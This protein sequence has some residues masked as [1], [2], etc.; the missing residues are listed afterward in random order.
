VVDAGRVAEQGAADDEH[1][2]A[3]GRSVWD[4]VGGDPTVDL[5]LDVEATTVEQ[6]TQRRHLGLHGREVGLSAEAGIHRHDEDLSDV[7]EDPL[8]VRQRRG[9]VDGHRRSGAESGDHSE[10]P[11]EVR[12][13]LGVYEDLLASSLH[14]GGDQ[15]VGLPHHQ[16]RLKGKVHERSA[17]GD[18]R[19][20]HGD[21]GHELSVHDV[22]VDAPDAGLLELDDGVSESGEVGV[23]HRRCDL[24]ACVSHGTLRIDDASEATGCLSVDR[25]GIGA[26]WRS[27][28]GGPVSTGSSADRPA[29]PPSPGGSLELSTVRLVAGGDAL[30]RTEDG[31][32]VLVEGALPNER[33]LA[34]VTEVR[35]R[36][37]RA[38]LV[39][40]ITPAPERVDPT[41]PE[42]ERGCGGCD[43]A[44]A[45]A[46]AQPELKAEVVRDALRRI[47]RLDD[48]PVDPGVSLAATGYRTTVR[49]AVRA[50]HAGFRSRRSHEVVVVG[51]CEVAHPSAAELLVDGVY[52]GVEEVVIRVG[53]RTGERM[54]VAH[55]SAAGVSVPDDVRVVGTDELRRGRRA[56]IHEEVDGHRFRVSA[57]SFFQACPDGAE[58]LVDAV[59]RALGGPAEDAELIDLYGGVGLFSVALGTAA[60]V[61]VERSASAVADARVNLVGRSARLFKMAVRRWRPTPAD[62]VVADPARAGLGSDGVSAVTGTAASRV[63]LVSCDPAS[64]ARDT[65]ALVGVGYRPVG[66]ELVDLFPQTHHIEAVTTFELLEPIRRAAAV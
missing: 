34:T 56:W 33:I 51:G 45:A 46:A 66:V 47:A 63:A 18:D 54:V 22:P 24:D 15:A 43:F 11:V 62:L 7:L 50:A 10:R 27:T 59:R 42:V 23:Q 20:S 65:A 25:G 21:V 61:L 3:C 6:F 17:G 58:A 26:W 38:Q 40:V 13:R 39:E 53:A 14:E 44:L 28:Y 55:P 57:E 41:C 37:I 30:A 9:G 29:D 60:P 48:L 5:D 36:L 52:D 2:G 49:A 35:A 19:R 12:A 64:L 8:D 16:V 4:G 1:R 32:V 31:Q